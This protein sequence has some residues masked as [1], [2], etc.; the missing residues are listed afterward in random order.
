MDRFLLH[1]ANAVTLL[2]GLLAFVVL[3]SG[4][5]RSLG[6]EA[7]IGDYV[8]AGALIVIPYCFAGTLHRIVGIS[9]KP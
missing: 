3:F 5:S 4:L 2:F 6:G 8:L 1:V 9:S 7:A